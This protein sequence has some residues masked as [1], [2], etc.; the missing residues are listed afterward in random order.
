MP[1]DRSEW[2]GKTLVINFWATWCPPCREEIPEFIK[3]QNAMRSQ[4]LQFIGI[5]IEDAKPVKAFM[6][7]TAFNYPVLIGEN[8]G[9]S[10]SM[11]LGNQLWIRYRNSFAGGRHLCR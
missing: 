1:H 8:G 7:E 9:M 6:S 4:G 2:N 11:H 10:L 5:A 3:L